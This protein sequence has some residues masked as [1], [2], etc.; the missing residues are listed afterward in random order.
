MQEISNESQ[1]QS[2]PSGKPLLPEM[3]KHLE[4]VFT[5]HA[6]IGNQSTRYEL[7]RDNA[8]HLAILIA[9]S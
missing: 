1:D 9:Q 4:G 6:P 8:K 2:E 5:Y 3:R 7:L